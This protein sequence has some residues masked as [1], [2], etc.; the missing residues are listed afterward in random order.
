MAP[1]A[2]TNQKVR[3]KPLNTLL[4][5]TY[6]ELADCEAH[7]ADVAANDLDAQEDVIALNDA[8]AHEA[9]VAENAVT[10]NE[11]EVACDAVKLAEVI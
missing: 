9:V 10:A 1:E 5:V 8:D 11:A 4:A 7:E 6:E 2:L 3:V